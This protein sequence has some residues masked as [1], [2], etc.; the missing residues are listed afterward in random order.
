MHLYKQ[1]IIDFPKNHQKN[2]NLILKKQFLI[3]I[4]DF[5]KFDKILSI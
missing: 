3:R 1:Y 4:G 5:Y 2:V